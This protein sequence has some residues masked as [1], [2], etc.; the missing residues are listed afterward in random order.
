MLP[1]EAREEVSDL[2]ALLAEFNDKQMRA[3]S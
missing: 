3:D 1:Q 2:N